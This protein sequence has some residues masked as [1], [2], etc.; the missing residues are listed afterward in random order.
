M[1]AKAPDAPP[2]GASPSG[3]A[4]PGA[5]ELAYQLRDLPDLLTPTQVAA[6]LGYKVDTVLSKKYR[7]ELPGIIQINKRRWLMQKSE[8]V[9]WLRQKSAPSQ[10]SSRWQ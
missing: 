8:L 6:V 9:R 5:R 3:G 1:T 10:E 2:G 4:A 7:G